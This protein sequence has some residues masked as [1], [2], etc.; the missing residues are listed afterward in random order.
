MAVGVKR[1]YAKAYNNVRVI[2]NMA[3]CVVVE[4]IYIW[5]RTSQAETKHSSQISFVLPLVVCILLAITVA[6]NSIA[7][8]YQ[9]FIKFR[10]LASSKKL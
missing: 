8:I 2:A 9:I 10:S 6:Y 3:V 1:P 4:S 7:I 5:Y